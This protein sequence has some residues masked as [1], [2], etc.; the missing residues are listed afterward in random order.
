MS[1]SPQ[2]GAVADGN[3]WYQMGGYSQQ[4]LKGQTWNGSSW[5][6]PN[7]LSY[8]KIYNDAN[9]FASE[10]KKYQSSLSDLLN[11]PGS[12]TSNPMYQFAF[13]QG[14][15]AINRTAAAKGQLGSGNRLAD[16]TKYGQG[17]ASQNFFNLADLYSTLSGAKS[18]NPAG[19]ASAAA[20]AVNQ[21]NS[22]YKPYRM[23]GG[24]DLSNF[25]TNQLY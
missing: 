18:Q 14:M 2:L 20:N 10:A 6:S 13:D 1:N 9:P 12:M 3:T 15:E 19:A 25:E 21:Q 8:D 22:L 23:T 5:T 17:L 24:S 7:A 11:N 4:P 16:L